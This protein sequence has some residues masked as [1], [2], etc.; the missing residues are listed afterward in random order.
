[1]D[2]L[3]KRKKFKIKWYFVSFLRDGNGA[4]VHSSEVK[5][6]VQGRDRRVELGYQLALQCR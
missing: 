3:I 1:M 4:I 5:A 6:L 2:S